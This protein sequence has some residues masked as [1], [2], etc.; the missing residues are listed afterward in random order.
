MVKGKGWDYTFF[1]VLALLTRVG[2]SFESTMELRGVAESIARELGRDIEMTTM[3]K[4][5]IVTNIKEMGM[6]EYH[7]SSTSDCKKKVTLKKE[8]EEFI[9]EWIVLSSN[10]VIDE[11]DEVTES[12]E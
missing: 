1:I 5:N 2:Q 6:I 10:E 8:L 12:T 3:A 7:P 11:V 4:H 9:C